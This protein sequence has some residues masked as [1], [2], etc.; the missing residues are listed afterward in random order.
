MGLIDK[1]K[2][3]W[4]AFVGYDPPNNTISQYNYSHLGQASYYNP[5]RVVLKKGTEKTV[6]GAIFNRIAIDCSS[7]DINHVRLDENNRYLKTIKSGLNECLTLEAN[8]DQTGKMLIRDLVISMFDEGCVALCPI[9]T[10]SN[11]MRDNKY[12]IYSMRVCKITQWYPDHVKLEAYNDKTGNK[13]EIV[14]PKSEVA[15]IE[16][17]LF[18][19]MNEPYSIAQRLIHKLALL[20]AIDDQSGSGKLDLIVQLP[21]AIKT[22]SRKT[23]AMDRRKDIEDQLNN[24]KYGIAYI[25]GTEKVTQLNRPV[26]NN[27]LKTIEF[28]TRMLNNQLGITDEIMNGTANE[29]TM[30]NYMNRTIRPIMDAIVD[31]LKR[32]FLTKTAR[33]Q[34]QTIMY[35]NDP[36]KLVPISKLADMADKFTRNEVMSSNEMRQIIGLKP[37][38]DA[39]ADELRNKNLNPAEGQEFASTNVESGV[40]SST[41]GETSQPVSLGDMPISLLMD[42]A[43]DEQGE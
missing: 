24:S 6:V 2:H 38:Q 22:E 12:D 39:R 33:T 11:P 20:D 29:E 17:P 34:G 7:I 10:S 16:N 3:A 8:K 23:I 42:Y 13:V 43:N 40:P 4:N 1:L 26:E 28:L 41:E 31:E 35:F 27:L 19:I 21:Y 15:I 37:I 25:D 5:S 36:F 18:A 32:K 30:L 9:D 14:M